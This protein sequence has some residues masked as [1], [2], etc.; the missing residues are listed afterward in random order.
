MYLRAIGVF[1]GRVIAL[2]PFIVYK[3][4]YERVSWMVT[5]AC[6]LDLIP[7]KQLFPTPPGYSCQLRVHSAI[8]RGDEVARTSSEDHDMELAAGRKLATV[9]D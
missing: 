7:V 1:N 4:G 9:S 5:S 2:D 8:A 3:L 6:S